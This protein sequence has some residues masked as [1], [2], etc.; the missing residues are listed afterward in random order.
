MHLVYSGFIYSFFFIYIIA[1]SSQSIYVTEFYFLT[2]VR[3]GNSKNMVNIVPL[4][5]LL[6]PGLQKI[7]KFLALR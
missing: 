6:L 3:K 2:V 7:G 1:N 4:V 5:Y